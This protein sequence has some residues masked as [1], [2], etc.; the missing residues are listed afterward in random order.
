MKIL[1]VS[2][3][4]WSATGYGVQTKATVEL[5]QNLGHEVAVLG[6]AGLL[7]GS[8]NW[9]GMT[10]Y[11]AREHPMGIDVVGTYAAHFDADAVLTLYDIWAFPS[12][13]KRVIGKPWIAMVPVDGVP[14]SERSRC[15]A[16]TSYGSGALRLITSR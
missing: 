6:L 16:N 1:W 13:M 8:L 9:R 7:G 4:P 2:N 11:P 14:V 12:D 3:P 15:S 10:I 5:L